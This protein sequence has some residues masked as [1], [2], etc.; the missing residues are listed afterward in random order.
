MIGFALILGHLVGDYLAQTDWMASN[1]ANQFRGGA[2]PEMEVVTER[3]DGWLVKG[4]NPALAIWNRVRRAWWRGHAACTAHCLCYTLAVWAFTFSWMPWWGLAA[5]FCAHWPVDRYR[6]AG[7]WMRNVS[8]QAGFASGPLAPWSVV[9]VDN[10]FHL[11][12]LYAIA[13]LA[14]AAS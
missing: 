4:P 10:T 12:T 8:G 9:V 11:L 2:R 1:K 6:L 13:L 5:C 3:G 7:R 14:G